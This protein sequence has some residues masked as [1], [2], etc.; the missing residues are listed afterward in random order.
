MQLFILSFFQEKR[1]R[2][3]A[4]EGDDFLQVVGITAEYNPF[5]TGH[6]RQLEAVRSAVGR[7]TPIVAALSGD[8][9]QRGEAACFSKFARAEAAVRCGVSLVLELP[10]PW[11]LSSAEGF[12]RGAVGM[13]AA[14]GVVDTISFGSES[15]AL[16]SLRLCADVL[17]GAEF[18]AA[19][20]AELEN[21]APFASVRERAV[22]RLAGGEAAARLRDPNDAL[23]VEYIR[24][25]AALGAGFSWFPVKRTGAAHDRVGS[26]SE[27]RAKMAAG[28]NWLGSVPPDAA[29]VFERLIAEGRGPVTS[30]SLRLPLLSRLRERSE[31]DFASLPDVSEG[32]E[33]KL[34]RAAQELCSA[35][36]IAQAAKSRRYALS[37]LR[38][39]VMCAALGVERGMAEG[40]PP[41]L[42]VLAMDERGEALLRRMRKT[43]SLPVIIK[44]AHIRRCD[45]AAQSIFA[46]GSR[47]HDLYVLGYS[48]EKTRRGGEDYRTSPFRPHPEE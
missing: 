18:P 21:G 29:E 16:D 47:A 10:L 7:D 26:A 28:E 20:R 23:A 39:I 3:S 27:L 14:A 13:L 24:A 37:R 25:A 33:H 35:E 22:A 8:F 42:R 17:S 9:V 30:A 44:P 36:E 43:A 12:A 19:L 31:A 32:L 1:N 34:F 5:H 6:L 45:A 38:R 41:Y 15:G 46:L 4:P 2:K 11:S 48:F 40:V